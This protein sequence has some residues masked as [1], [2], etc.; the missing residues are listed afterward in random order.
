MAV[1]ADSEKLIR[2]YYNLLAKAHDKIDQLGAENEFLRDGLQYI[3]D[4]ASGGNVPESWPE[5]AADYLAALAD[6]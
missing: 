6:S 2:R 3:A 1:M 5:W 4:N